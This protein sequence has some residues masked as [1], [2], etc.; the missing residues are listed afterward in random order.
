MK[1]T[2]NH[3]KSRK[4]SALPDNSVYITQDYYREDVERIHRMQRELRIY[5]FKMIL[6][7]SARLI[8]IVG[9]NILSVYYAKKSGV[10][11][12]SLDKYAD[13][14]MTINGALITCILWPYCLKAILAYVGF[15]KLKKK[16]EAGKESLAKYKDIVEEEYTATFH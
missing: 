4:S 11:G 6:K 1:R 7:R 2:R 5:W 3:H 10:A 12:E 16:F 14:I 15:R 13:W 8:L 9:A